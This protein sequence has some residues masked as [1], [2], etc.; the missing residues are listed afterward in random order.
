MDRDLFLNSSATGNRFIAGCR[1]WVTPEAQRENKMLNIIAFFFRPPL[2]RAVHRN[3]L[4]S[5]AYLA[6]FFL[7]TFRRNSP[8]A[9][10]GNREG[11][12]RRVDGALE[13][14]RGGC[15]PAGAAGGASS[16]T[17]IS[18]PA[19]RRHVLPFVL[20]RK[21]H[22]HYCLYYQS[23]HAPNPE[24]RVMLHQEKGF[25]WDA[26]TAG[27]NQIFGAG[28][29]IR[30]CG[31]A[32]HPP[33]AIRGHEHGRVDLWRGRVAPK[34]LRHEVE[35]FNSS[36]ASKGRRACPPSPEDGVVDANCRVHR[37][38]NLFVAGSSVFPTSGHAN[39]T[40]TIV[41]LAVRLA[42]HLKECLRGAK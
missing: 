23:E 26:A 12:P 5:T 13:N 41:A 2:G 6:K 8:G 42:D 10:G 11:E 9:R 35:D 36:G 28:R 3:A 20:P 14:R 32:P 1:F 22:N 40:L 27:E 19:I 33:K 18:H 30:C 34:G 25:F 31:L 15:A 39:P 37:V 29:G 4:F 7:T 24:S 21:S 38:A 16:A 17:G